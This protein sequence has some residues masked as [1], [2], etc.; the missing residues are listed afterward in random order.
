VSK[1]LPSV[2]LLTSPQCAQRSWPPPPA[3]SAG[4]LHLLQPN[5][6]SN[7]SQAPHLMGFS[8]SANGTAIHTDTQLQNLALPLTPLVLTPNPI[9]QKNQTAPPK[10]IQNLPASIST[11]STSQCRSIREHLAISADTLDCHHWGGRCYWARE[12]SNDVQGCPLRQRIT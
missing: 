11:A 1:L 4:A 5:I 10:C 12:P 3:C 2:S 6:T 7:S 9:Y 8:S